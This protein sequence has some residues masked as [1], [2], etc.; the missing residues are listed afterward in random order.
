MKE[1][2]KIFIIIPKN[3][4]GGAEKVM[5][6]LANEFA[7]YNLKIFFITLSKTKNIKFEKR[8][9]LI[10]LN[11]NRSL[12]SIFKLTKLINKIK[13]QICFS[14]IS[15]TNII[16]FFALKISHHKCDFF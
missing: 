9:N 13:P 2:K 6:A 7:R 4:V 14:T 15:H 11:S 10:R 16:L 5:I 12:S 1:D 3:K 8:I